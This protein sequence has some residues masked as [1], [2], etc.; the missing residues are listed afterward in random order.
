MPDRID[1]PTTEALHAVAVAYLGRHGATRATLARMLNRHIDRWARTHGGDVAAPVAMA[2]RA[3]REVVDRLA[4]AGAVDD[5][6]FA[7][8]RSRRLI[9]GG[10]SRRATAAH[11]AARGVPAEVVAA[12]LPSPDDMSELEAAVAYAR[13]RRIGPFRDDIAA[14]EA[15]PRELG[16]LA[17]A[18]FGREVAQRALAMPREDAEAALARLRRT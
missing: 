2:K 6:R 4:A 3:V 18:G 12:A 15:H 9:R 17:R 5:A 7:A 14:A 13:K 1:P 8:L 11:L 16:A 10:H